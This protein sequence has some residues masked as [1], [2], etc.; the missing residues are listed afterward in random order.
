MLYKEDVQ[1]VKELIRYTIEDRKKAEESR[2]WEMELELARLQAGVKS[3]NERTGEDCDSLDELVK[4]VQNLTKNLCTFEKEVASHI[5]VRA[6]NDWFR[7][8]EFAKEIDLYNTSRGKSLKPLPN[9]LPRS[10]PVKNKS[11]IFLSEVKDS[12]SF[13]DAESHPLY[14]CAVYLKRSVNKKIDLIETNNICFNCFDASLERRTVNQNLSFR[15]VKRDIK[16]YIMQ[17]DH[18]TRS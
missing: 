6:G 4:S 5:S 12:K 10:N 8:L 1:F 7:P 9:V 2:L 11:R 18:R 14:K 13:C 17:R 15:S 16:R 3:E